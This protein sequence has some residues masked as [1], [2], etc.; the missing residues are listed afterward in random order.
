MN[1]RLKE[2][3]LLINDAGI[4][5][6]PETRI[7][8]GWEMQF[9]VNHIGHFALTKELL[10]AATQ[11]VWGSHLQYIPEEFSHRYSVTFQEKRWSRWVGSTRA[12]DRRRRRRR[13]SNRRNG[14]APRRCGL[15]P[16]PFRSA[17]RVC[18]ARTVISQLRRKRDDPRRVTSESMITPAATSRPKGSGR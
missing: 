12:A 2:P 6:C 7:G 10:F 5:A 8:P 11:G 18:I 9:G 1:G 4:M 16:H 13:C 15:Q 17:K 3:D 14:V